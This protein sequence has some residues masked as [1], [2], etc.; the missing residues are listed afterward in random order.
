MPVT[1]RKSQGY[2]TLQDTGDTVK[3]S[4]LGVLYKFL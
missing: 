3:H 4:M 2:I 1:D